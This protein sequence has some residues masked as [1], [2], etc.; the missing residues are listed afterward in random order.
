MKKLVVFL[1]LVGLTVNI[2]AFTSTYECVDRND[3]LKFFVNIDGNSMHYRTGKDSFYLFNFDKTTKAKNK[4]LIHT[5]SK[6][7]IHYSVY[8]KESNPIDIY[9]D[10]YK[11]NKLRYEYKC[12]L[13][14]ILGGDDEIPVTFI[15]IP[16]NKKLLNDAVNKYKKNN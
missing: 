7:T 5:F 2:H 8:Q 10:D 4:A 13:D 6:G 1:V 12:K 15:T 16:N 11:D 3:G 9:I 14:S